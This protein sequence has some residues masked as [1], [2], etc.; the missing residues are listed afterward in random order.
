MRILI[1]APLYPP[2]TGTLATYIKEVASRLAVKHTVSVV[3]YGSEPEQ[4]PNVQM[5]CTSKQWP[6]LVR[7]ALFTWRLWCSSRGADLL[8][9]SDG[10][11]VGTPSIFIGRIRRIPV[12]RFVR[13][14][15]ARERLEQL[16]RT[17]I[18]EEAFALSSL[19]QLKIRFIR[20]LQRLVLRHSKKVLMPNGW[21]K[22]IFGRAYQIPQKKMVVL[23]Y[24]PER[25]ER[26]SFPLET[27]PHQLLVTS[28]LTV[29]SGVRELIEQ[30]TQVQQQV[31]DLSLVI[32]NDGPEERTLR[33]H[34]QTLGLDS[35]IQ[36]LGKVSR[37]ERAYLL[38][39]SGALVLHPNAQHA[40]HDVYAAYQANLPVVTTDTQDTLPAVLTDQEL[41]EQL[42]NEGTQTMNRQASWEHHLQTI[43]A[44]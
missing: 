5:V 20:W 41:R 25:L 9:V 10:A 7:T 35:A 16:T 6:V 31:P 38:Q 21:L 2:D 33:A 29:T 1:V 17:T 13:E 44:L 12:Y 15:E 43:L 11:S 30:F 34:V 37:V 27:K 32:A 28:P 39:T 24:P 14:D 42:I 36:F 4:A 8:Y 22:D 26:V 23:P 19:P 18:P 3:A 40:S